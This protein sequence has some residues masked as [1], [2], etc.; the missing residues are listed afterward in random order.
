MVNDYSSPSILVYLNDKVNEEEILDILYGIEE[1]GIPYCIKRDS[2]DNS[3]S[4]AFIGANKSKLSVG[5]GIDS[6]GYISL[7]MDKLKEG[8][9]LFIDNLKS[10]EKTKRA[11]GSNGAR[12]VKGMPLKNLY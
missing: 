1:E 3:N 4:L 11:F 12:L 9:S 5:I 7:T 8:T 10:D 2:V 6:K